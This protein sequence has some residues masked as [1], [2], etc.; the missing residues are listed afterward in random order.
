MNCE[1]CHKE[2]VS[3]TAYEDALYAIIGQWL[4][5]HTCMPWYRFHPDYAAP[6]EQYGMIFISNYSIRHTSQ[7]T[8]QIGTD[9]STANFC[10]AIDETEQFD[11]DLH[12]FKEAGEPIKCDQKSLT[13][14]VQR[15]A[16][17]LLKLVNNKLAVPDFTTP[18]Q[19]VGINIE[20]T[21]GINVKTNLR[22]KVWE[23]WA[24]S[25]HRVTNCRKTSYP[26]NGDE[27]VY[28][29]ELCDGTPIC[30][31]KECREIN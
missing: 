11:L 25:N 10:I 12:V 9:L 28:C 30:K 17:D 23:Y 21:D 19:K 27:L 29:V 20:C 3:A 5:E 15:S 1:Y 6:E 22:N 8:R 31:A 13:N 2:L 7:E 24:E 16:V 4:C 18:L 26:I 14:N